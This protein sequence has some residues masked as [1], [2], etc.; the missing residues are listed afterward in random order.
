LNI[1]L[2]NFGPFGIFEDFDFEPFGPFVAFV[3]LDFDFGP[4]VAFRAL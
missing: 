3:D 1:F 2:L 4:F